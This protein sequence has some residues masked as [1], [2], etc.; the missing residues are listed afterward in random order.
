MLHASDEDSSGLDNNLIDGFPTT[1]AMIRQLRG[2]LRLKSSGLFCL[3][4][5]QGH[6]WI[7]LLALGLELLRQLTRNRP[8]FGGSWTVSRCCIIETHGV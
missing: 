2:R 6:N 7:E 5:I 3:T 8:D 4:L 1:P